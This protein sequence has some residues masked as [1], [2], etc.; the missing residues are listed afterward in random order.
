MNYT[1][2]NIVPLED[3]CLVQVEF[4]PD[5]M[6]KTASAQHPFVPNID[7]LRT[8]LLMYFQKHNPEL[9]ECKFEKMMK[10]KGH[11]ILWLPPYTPELQPIK[12]FWAIGKNYAQY[13]CS[14]GITMKSTL[15][16]LKWGWYGNHHLFD[17]TGNRNCDIDY[18]ITKKDPVDC[19]KLFD[20]SIK[21]MNDKYIKM[22]GGISGTIGNLIV[23]PNYEGD[24]TG[25]PV[26]F[27]LNDFMLERN[28]ADLLPRDAVDAVARTMTNL[29]YTNAEE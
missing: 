15:Q 7:E 28:D 17:E 1:N 21:L 20:H 2:V 5:E 26:D 29:V 3:E 24:V 10:A 9:L 11:V 23:D 18:R 25:I 16:H 12:W 13:L 19:S 8:G 22:C 14:A 4:L 6:K 27:L